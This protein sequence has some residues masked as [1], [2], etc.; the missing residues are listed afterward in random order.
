MASTKETVEGIPPIVGVVG[1]TGGI[2]SETRAVAHALGRAIVQR[3]W[4][5]VTGSCKKD[6]QDAATADSVKDAAFAGARTAPT[7]ASGKRV[8]ICRSGGWA[9]TFTPSDPHEAFLDTTLKDGRN[10][11]T[12]GVPDVV[13]ALR[14]GAG[15]LSEVAYAWRGNKTVVCVDSKVKL[16]QSLEQ[17]GQDRN[18]KL[19]SKILPALSQTFRYASPGEIL[20][21]AQSALNSAIVVSYSPWDCESLVK[22]ACDAAERA[23][24][25]PRCDMLLEES[26][27]SEQLRDCLA[28]LYGWLGRE[29]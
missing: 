21:A 20:Q 13:F 26:A 15:T 29:V 14:G 24:V 27:S 7:G 6:N 1:G 2:D 3:G 17:V 19:Y 8:G 11:L 5:L 25:R 12:G 9:F 28:K 10:A 16:D 18:S 22:T 4:T 23:G